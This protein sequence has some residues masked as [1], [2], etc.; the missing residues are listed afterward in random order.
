MRMTRRERKQYKRDCIIFWIFTISFVVG[1]FCFCAYMEQHYPTPRGA[2][3]DWDMAD[4]FI[5]WLI[6]K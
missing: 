4:L 5:I 1:L 2:V 3:K 6:L